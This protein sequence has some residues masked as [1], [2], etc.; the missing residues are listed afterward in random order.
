MKK[1]NKKGH[2]AVAVLTGSAIAA[3]L[4]DLRIMPDLL[5]VLAA[6][7]AGLLPDLDHKTSTVSNTMQFSAKT[8]K[9]LRWASGMAVG[10]GAVLFFLHQGFPLLWI[11][12]GLCLAVAA[13]LRTLILSGAGL[14][15]VGAYL[16]YDEHWLLLLAGLALLIMPFVKHRGLI[17]SPEFAVLLSAGV[18]TFTES[19][20]PLVYAMGLGV[21]AGWWS[22]LLADSVTAEGIHSALLPRLKVAL[23][24]IRNGGATERW[25]ARICWAASVVLWINLFHVK[26]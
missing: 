23:N 18:I 10:V 1:M 12:T 21:I 5:L 14:L 9:K 4:T 13:R 25:V 24:V 26:G 20:T 2:V 7:V 22:H 16:H 6:G 17:H 11:G 19:Q 15:M 3:H 8:R